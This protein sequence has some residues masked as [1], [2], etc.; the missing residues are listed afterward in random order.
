LGIRI[1][2][3]CVAAGVV[4]SAS[5]ETDTADDHPRRRH[6]ALNPDSTSSLVK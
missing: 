6:D 2:M 1:F 4:I 5:M 3:E